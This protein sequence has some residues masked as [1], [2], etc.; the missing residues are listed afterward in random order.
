M[1][2]GTEQMSI[3]VLLINPP[4]KQVYIRD[5]YCS[6][7]SK[8]NYLFH[9]VD[10]LMMSGRLS[11]NHEVHVMDAMAERTGIAAAISAIDTLAP[12]VIFAMIGAVA[13]EDDVAFL[14]LLQPRC[15]ISPV[16]MS[17]ATSRG[18]L[19]CLVLFPG[20]TGMKRRRLH[21]PATENMMCRYRATISLRHAATASLL[22]VIANLPLF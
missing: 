21:D 10:L 16:K 18:W 8:S 3:R 6:K 17:S 14:A 12:D 11:E 7:F 15:S 9:P 1:A 20:A 5:Y 13:V 22:C 4:G 2:G 19:I